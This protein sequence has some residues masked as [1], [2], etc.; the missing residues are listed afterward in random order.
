MF[1]NRGIGGIIAIVLAT[2]IIVTFWVNTAKDLV[3]PDVIRHAAEVVVN[4]LD[5]ANQAPS[6]ASGTN[7][8]TSGR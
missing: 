7:L 4:Y 1:Q 5:R 8:R 6:G 3:G 2:M